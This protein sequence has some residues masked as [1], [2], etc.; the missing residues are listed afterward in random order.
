MYLFDIVAL[1]NSLICA[2]LNVDSLDFLHTKLC[3]FKNSDSFIVSNPCV[4]CSFLALL[5]ALR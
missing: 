2:N 4:L 1:L 3:H 5:P